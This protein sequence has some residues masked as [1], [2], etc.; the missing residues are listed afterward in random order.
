MILGTEVGKKIDILLMLPRA[1]RTCFQI[2]EL[3]KPEDKKNKK[4][5]TLHH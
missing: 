4:K 5:P 2:R 1:E 3:E